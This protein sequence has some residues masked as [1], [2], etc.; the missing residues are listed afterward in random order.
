[1]SSV[2][3]IDCNILQTY[4]EGLKLNIP[5]SEDLPVYLTQ[6]PP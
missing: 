2:M 6:T 5:T 1:M 3:I 4:P